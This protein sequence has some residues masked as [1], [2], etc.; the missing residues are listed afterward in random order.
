M[1]DRI[2]VFGRYTQIDLISLENIPL[3]GDT[4]SLIDGKVPTDDTI[5]CLSAQDDKSQ[6]G[7]YNCKVADNKYSLTLIPQ[8][9]LQASENSEDKY[10]A[11]YPFFFEVTNGIHYGTYK[12]SQDGT[13]AS[14]R[15]LTWG[16]NA[17]S[18]LFQE[19]T[20]DITLVPQSE[21]QVNI[22]Y[23][24][25]FT[26]IFGIFT[27][28]N[29]DVALFVTERVGKDDSLDMQIR[30]LKNWSPQTLTFNYRI[31]ILGI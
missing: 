19:E 1:K 13:Y 12:Y 20:V 4:A 14:F 22:T 18:L 27:Q 7:F 16:S 3:T 24:K 25:P 9:N 30:H 31:K 15:Q 21:T 11:G 2:S 26:K 6:L 8:M 29:S 23:K 5:I 28:F 17:N 10:N